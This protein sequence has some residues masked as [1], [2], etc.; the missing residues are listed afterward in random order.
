MAEEWQHENYPPFRNARFCPLI[1]SETCAVNVLKF[2]T[3]SFEHFSLS[4]LK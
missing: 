2:R 3:L 1:T 4:D